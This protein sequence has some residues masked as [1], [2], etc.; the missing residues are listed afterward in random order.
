MLEKV[1]L[2]RELPKEE[3]KSVIDGLKNRL[4]ELQR[5]ARNLG[6]PVVIVFEGWDAAGKGTMINRL[7]ISMDPRG[8]TVHPI[9]PPNEEERFRPFLWR[10]WTKT[11]EKGRIAIFDRSWYGR[12][13]VERVDRHVKRRVWE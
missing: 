10:F 2:S 7:L 5:K 4:G 13:L 3:Y 6:I 1:D 8:F 11:P 12:V 9:N